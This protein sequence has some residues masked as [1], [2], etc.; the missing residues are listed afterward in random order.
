MVENNF[1]NNANTQTNLTDEKEVGANYTIELN[2]GTTL[3]CESFSFSEEAE[4][5]EVSYN[6]T[7]AQNI[8]VTGVTYSGSFD[9]PGN[10]DNIRTVGWDDG[11]DNS[12]STTLPNHVSSLTVRSDAD[13][14]NTYSFSNV[15]LNSHSK[16]VPSDDR[17]SQSFDFM[18]E[19][20][21]VE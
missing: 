19:K 14:A 15:M 11:G 10:A 18:A 17:T 20:L 8:A 9:I 5:S 13:G 3:R 6:S 12:D 1:N 21:I 7:F 4:T 16:D 2:D